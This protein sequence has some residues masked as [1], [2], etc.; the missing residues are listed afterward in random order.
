MEFLDETWTKNTIEEFHLRLGS[1]QLPTVVV[2]PEKNGVGHAVG[3]G[4]FIRDRFQPFCPK[5][6]HA[7]SF[8]YYVRTVIYVKKKIIVYIP[9]FL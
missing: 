6:V 3:L 7:D 4:H 1:Q 8:E 9:L 2:N 5:E